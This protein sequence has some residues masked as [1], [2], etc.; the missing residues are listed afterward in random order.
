MT[1]GKSQR[2]GEKMEIKSCQFFSLRDVRSYVGS[3][4][5]EI[6]NEC[7]RGMRHG[8]RLKCLSQAKEEKIDKGNKEMLPDTDMGL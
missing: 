8:V 2:T 5:S 1:V 6:K 7:A 4:I 3:I